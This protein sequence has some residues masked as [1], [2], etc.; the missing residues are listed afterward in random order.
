MAQPKYARVL[1]K[2][3]GEALADQSGYGISEQS[4]DNLVCQLKE[5]VALGV[6]VG[7]VVG[8]GN[9]WRGRQSDVMDKV[10]CDHM[11]MLATVI[12]A[13]ALQ[14]HLEMA[15][16]PA[17]VQSAVKI[18]QVAE[19]LV[20][21]KAIKHLQNGCIVIFAGGTGSPFFT[22]DTAAALRA[23]EIKADCMLCAKASDGIYDSDPVLNT[24]AVRFDRISYM[25]VI[26]RNLQAMDVTA[27]SICKENHIPVLVFGK[28]DKHGIINAVTGEKVGTIIE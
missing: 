17:M 14:S 4:I 11:G 3:S 2:I 23:A 25:E 21:K 26:N 19:T 27:I 9:I 20:V 22:T 16:V 28:H 5:V 7:I 1:L 8:G 12:N 13:L 6:Q 18:E 10:T 24:N 15:G